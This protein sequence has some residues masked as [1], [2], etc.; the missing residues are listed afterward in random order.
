[1]TAATDTSRPSPAAHRERLGQR[2][3]ASLNDEQ[4]LELLLTFGTPRRHVAS[5]AIETLDLVNLEP[6]VLRVAA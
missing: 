6:D 4:K 1:M 3:A 2:S 5:I